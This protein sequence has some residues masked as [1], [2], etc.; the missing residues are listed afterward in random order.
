[1]TVAIVLNI[2]GKLISGCKL[3]LFIRRQNELG[4]GHA[5]VD[6]PESV[7]PS[8]TGDSRRSTC[9][10]DVLRPRGGDGEL[11][12][13]GAGAAHYPAQYQSAHR[14]ARAASRHPVAAS[15]DAQVDSEPR[16]RAL[17]R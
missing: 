2:C 14:I 12:C 7:Q 16:G 9:F 10:D 1:M 5:A 3:I 13:C 6:G 17:L 4:W 8:A 15:L 11:F